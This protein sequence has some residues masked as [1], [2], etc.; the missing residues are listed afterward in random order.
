[1]TPARGPQTVFLFDLCCAIFE[2]F[3]AMA[4]ERGAA[5]TK[6]QPAYSLP[7]SLRSGQW[8]RSGDK[9]QPTYSLQKSRRSGQWRG[10]GNRQQPAYPLQKSRRSGQWR[11][12]GN[13]QQAATSLFFAKIPAFQHN[14][15][16]N[17]ALFGEK[18]TENR[19][20]VYQK[21]IISDGFHR[22]SSEFLVDFIKFLVNFCWKPQNFR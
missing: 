15:F 17:K 3:R 7:K 16:Q 10:R 20:K 12:R 1:M 13:K 8:R 18:S 19:S 5:A 4:R 22:I 9:W 14:Y 21:S 6:R 2:E 11:R